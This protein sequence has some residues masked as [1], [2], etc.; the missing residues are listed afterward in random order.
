MSSEL[1]LCSAESW[2]SDWIPSQ[3]VCVPELAMDEY[4]MDEYQMGRDGSPF[5]TSHLI[6]TFEDVCSS[7]FRHK[8]QSGWGLLWY[9]RIALAVGVGW[10]MSGT[11]KVTVWHVMR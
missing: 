11:V 4:Q 9:V 2:F 6:E 10:M 7:L 1:D 8:E 3:C 5:Y